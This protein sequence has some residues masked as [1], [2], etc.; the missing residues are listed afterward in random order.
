MTS[1]LPL[2]QLATIG[3]GDP[4]ACPHCGCK[5]F[6]VVDS[7]QQGGT[8]RRQRACRNCSTPMITLEV[9]VPD[10]YQLAVVQLDVGKSD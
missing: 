2:A 4:W 8:R 10:G 6:K 1:Y 7:H 3:G 9:P 5:H